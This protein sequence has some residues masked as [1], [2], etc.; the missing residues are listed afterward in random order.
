MSNNQENATKKAFIEYTKLQQ[1]RKDVETLKYERP[2]IDLAVQRYNEI[3]KVTQEVLSHDEELHKS[4]SGLKP[5][6]RLTAT[7]GPGKPNK[8]KEII[9]ESGVLSSALESF[10][11]WYLP[12]EKQ[13]TIGFRSEE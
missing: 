13:R 10:I 2:A 6:E 5:L 3:L 11:R 7:T 8:V 12:V 9:V 1:L 4:I